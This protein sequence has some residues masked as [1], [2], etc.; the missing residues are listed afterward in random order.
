MSNRLPSGEKI[1]ATK[2]TPQELEVRRY[3]YLDMRIAG[4]TYRQIALAMGTSKSVVYNQVQKALS[5][6]AEE[7]S[8]AST[9]LRAIQMARYNVLLSRY[10]VDALKGDSDAFDHVLRVMGNMNKISGLEQ[11]IEL[12]ARFSE[13][14]FNIDR[15]DT[16]DGNDLQETLPLQQAEGSDI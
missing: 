6:M 3:Q 11:R 10:W 8:D 14:T 1:M 16:S 5:E 2:R 15:T 13:F 4:R 7:H 9:E 12:E